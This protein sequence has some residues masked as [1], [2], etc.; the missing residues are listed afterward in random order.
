MENNIDKLKCIPWSANTVERC[1]ENTGEDLK[2][3][4]LEQIMHR[5]R[6]ALWLDENTDASNMSQ[7]TVFARFCFSDETHE[8]LLFL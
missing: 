4:V 1:I 6:F 2:K 7:L 3:H 8:E 5:R